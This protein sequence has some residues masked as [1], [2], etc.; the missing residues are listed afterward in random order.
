MK[1]F[2]ISDTHGRLDR[3][4]DV[5][6]VLAKN[7]VPD[8]IVHCGDHYDD[9]SEISRHL[10]K[11]VLAVRGNCDRSF[12]EDEYAILETEAGNFLVTHGH[13]QNV[14]YSKQNLYYKAQE[15]DCVGAIYGHTHRAD[16]SNIGDFLFLNPGSL[17]FP[18]DGSG[19]T[20]AILNTQENFAEAK[21]WNYDDFMLVD[22]VNNP[23]TGN[24]PKVKGGKLRDL[25]NYSDGF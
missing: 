9:A 11:R 13:M 14:G 3:V 22:S 19:G 25:F 23:G 4:Y 5:Y 16:N 2:V 8:L 1:I 17:S 21:I 12:S 10:G 6:R 18:R 15:L 20:F 24:K 7:G